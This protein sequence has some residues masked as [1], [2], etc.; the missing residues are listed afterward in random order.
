MTL[1]LCFQTRFIRNGLWSSYCQ[2]IVATRWNDVFY[3]LLT[4]T[5]LSISA[6]TFRRT[7]CRQTIMSFFCSSHVR[8]VTP[9]CG[10][11]SAIDLTANRLWAGFS[12]G[13]RWKRVS[14]QFSFMLLLHAKCRHHFVEV[15]GLLLFVGRSAHD[16]CWHEQ[17]MF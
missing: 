2:V 5:V 17:N 4:L 9:M 15:E 3:V 13:N 11:N 12:D 1:R 10:K 7:W 14:W 6:P 16:T 8:L